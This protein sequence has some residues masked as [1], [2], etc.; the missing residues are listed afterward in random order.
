MPGSLPKKTLDYTTVLTYLTN[1]VEV[2]MKNNHFPVK[3]DEKFT[4][5]YK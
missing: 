3:A 2:N 4:F 1:V 5:E